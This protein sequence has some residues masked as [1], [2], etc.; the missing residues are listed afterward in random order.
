M[1]R[2]NVLVITLE[3]LVKEIKAQYD[4]EPTELIDEF[5]MVNEFPFQFWYDELTQDEWRAEVRDN[6]DAIYTQMLLAASVL[7]DE[8]PEG[9]YAFIV[10]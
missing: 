3:D 7:E 5:H 10:E 2:Q 8:C 6:G 9:E 4:V 1:K